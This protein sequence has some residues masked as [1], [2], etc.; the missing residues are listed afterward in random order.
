MPSLIRSLHLHLSTSVAAYAVIS[1]VVLTWTGLFGYGMRLPPNRCRTGLIP[2]GA[3]CCAPGQAV[4]DGHCVGT[5]RSCPAPYQFT[6]EGCVLPP[7]RVSLPGGQV[8]IGPSDW[9]SAEIAR[10]RQLSVLPFSIDR[11]EVDQ[12]RYRACMAAGS[13]PSVTLSAEP[14]LPVTGVS[15][16][17]AAAFCSSA[18]GRLPSA[19]EWM[20]AAL[21]QKGH[22]YPWGA[23]GLVCRRASFGLVTGPCAQQGITADLPGSRP[24]GMSPTG[25][26][27]LAG[28]VAEWTLDERGT[29][30]VRGGSFRS[31]S[32]AGLKSWSVA[33]ARVADDVGFRCVYDAVSQQKGPA[34]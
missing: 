10:E 30:G 17:A 27:D 11:G 12:A 14:G 21:G 33:P 29:P 22:R 24:D 2:L 26:F 8:T 16:E 15:A 34:P 4:R 13:C 6:H 9:D 20:Y 19:D 3:R 32:P 5:P 28:N 23:H 18:G 25:V 1:V 7:G 31:K